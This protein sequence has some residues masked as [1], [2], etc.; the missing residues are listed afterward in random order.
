MAVLLYKNTKV[1]VQGITGYQGSFHTKKM[2]EYGTNIVAGIT[3]GKQGMEVEGVPVYDSFEEALKHTEIDASIIFVPASFVKEAAFEAI[4]A[5]VKLLVIIT[6]GVPVWDT[7]EIALKAKEKGVTLIGPNCPGIITPG[8]AK[9]GIIPG[10]IVTPGKVGVV[11]RSGTLTYEVIQQ[12]TNAG[13]GQSTCIGIG[14]DPVHGIGFLEALELF[15][16]DPDTEQ[17]VMIGEIGGTAEEEAAEYIKEN[18]TKPVVAFIAGQTAPPGKQ[19]G[20]AGAIIMGSRGTAQS[21]IKALNE[22][23]VPV[24][25]TISEIPEILLKNKNK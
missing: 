13:L 10:N 20:H 16:N 17:I 18:I 24:T 5:G 7:A 23:G 6:E 9:M 4:E 21:K 11:S 12:L 25:K 14:G 15:Q 2:L 8:Q 3:P 19:M 1:A 22:A